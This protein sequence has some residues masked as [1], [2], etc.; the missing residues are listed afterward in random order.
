MLFLYDWVGKL[1]IHAHNYESCVASW[2]I[3]SFVINSLV[4]HHLSHLSLSLSLSISHHVQL[5]L[6]YSPFWMILIQE[7]A[8]LP[9]LSLMSHSTMHMTLIACVSSPFDLSKVSWFIDRPSLPSSY[10]VS[11]TYVESGLAYI[12]KFYLINYLSILLENGTWRKQKETFHV[13]SIVI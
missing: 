6:A 11:P 3:T 2:Y 5:G 7:F 1:N 12:C 10:Y 13:T 4:G 9:I 8:F